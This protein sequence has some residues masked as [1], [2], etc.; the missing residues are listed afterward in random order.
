MPQVNNN[1]RKF[2]VFSAKQ[3]EDEQLRTHKTEQVFTN[4]AQIS[5]LEDALANNASHMDSQLSRPK[6]KVDGS[7]L[8]SLVPS[9]ESLKKTGDMKLSLSKKG[10]EKLYVKE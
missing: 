6:K 1:F 10:L 4:H 9:Q 7:G 3:G 5:R 2:G 8:T